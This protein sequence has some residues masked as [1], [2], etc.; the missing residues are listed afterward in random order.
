MKKIVVL[1]FVSMFYNLGNSQTLDTLINVGKHQLYFKIIKGKGTPILFEAG[2]GD[3]SS[4]WESLIYEIHKKTNATI[5]TYDRAGLG[6]SEIDTT[7]ISFENEI[8]N[9][10]FALKKLGYSKKIFIVCHSF[11]GYYTSFFTYRNT[12]KVKGVICIDTAT[13]C[14]FTKNWS[15][16]FIKTIRKE[17][18]QM[19]KEYKIGLYYV[20]QNF[21]HT[22]QFMEGKFLNS[23]TPV[24][25]ICAENIQPIIK[26]K[27]KWIHC[28]E[29]FGL[30]P[31]HRYV[32]AKNAD[33]KVWEKNPSIVIEEIIKMYHR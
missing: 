31:N 24:T 8:K 17:D 11:G 5:I 14:F 16:D 12:K 6:K 7:K 30:M 27:D 32:I 23:K 25:L 33:H 1:I 2:N 3:D 22:A 9:L 13:P 28:C 15:D 21:N 26:E 29:N 10:E 4:V 20:L 19:I 18:W